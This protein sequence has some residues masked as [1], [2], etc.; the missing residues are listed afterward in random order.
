MRFSLCFHTLRLFRWVWYARGVA[1]R[2]RTGVSGGRR[3]GV[4]PSFTLRL[5]LQRANGTLIGTLTSILRQVAMGQLQRRGS[6]PTLIVVDWPDHGGAR[7]REVRELT[8]AELL[9][10]KNEFNRLT[11]EAMWREGRLARARGKRGGTVRV[12]LPGDSPSSPVLPPS[13]NTEG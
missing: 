7:A 1:G 13:S 2:G 11:A 8:C 12:P 10:A 9:G 5:H 6:R 3:S 4:C